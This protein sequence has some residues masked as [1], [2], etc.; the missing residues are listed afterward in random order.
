MWA[1]L[2]HGDGLRRILEDFYSRV[3]ADPR[4]SPFFRFITKGRA[5]EKQFSFLK[6]IFTGEECYFGDRPF[7][8]HHWMVI[9]D[10]LF[11]HRE[12][13]MEDCLRRYGLPEALVKKFRT[14][15]EVFRRQ[16]VKSAPKPRKL[17]GEDLPLEGFNDVEIAGGSL[18]D[19]CRAPMD[20]G[21]R[22][23]YHV[24][25]GQTYCLACKPSLDG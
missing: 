19:G 17:R 5:I 14:V 9:S 20:A 12:S 3:Y 24:R 25:T 1:A 4:L 22:A 10:E 2:G 6:E 18:C 7:N 13:L 11:E 8:A 15:D 23:R 16:I 21:V